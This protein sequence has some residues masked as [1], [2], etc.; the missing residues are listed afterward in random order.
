MGEVNDE[1]LVKQFLKTQELS[2]FDVLVRRHLGRVRVMIYPMVLND[3][4][5]DDLT[6]E[7]FLRVVHCLPGFQGRAR[8]VTWLH[9]I[10][11]NTTYDFLRHKQRCPIVAQAELPEQPD[12]AAGPRAVVQQ[13]ELGD[14]VSRALATLSPT[15]RAAI[16]LTAIEGLSVT[17][18][19][20]AAGC[21]AATMYWRV[22]QARKQLK[23]ELGAE[24]KS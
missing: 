11:L 14:T 3:A 15:L 19:A 21:L 22:H 16:T 23:A 12:Q 5:A 10:A 1:Q 6:Q 9:R 20:R 24:L 8:F 17:E 18:A 2:Y 4:D 7:V 13:H